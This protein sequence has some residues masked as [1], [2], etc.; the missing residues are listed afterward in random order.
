[1]F[2]RT[3]PKP[4]GSFSGV[5]LSNLESVMYSFSSF[6]LRTGMVGAFYRHT[7]QITV[8]EISTC[9]MLMKLLPGN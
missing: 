6:C 8:W 2:L 7:V 5:V 3:M 4:S 1:M 9:S